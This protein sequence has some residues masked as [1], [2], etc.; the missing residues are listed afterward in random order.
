MDE[1]AP[2]RWSALDPRLAEA[3]ARRGIREPTEIQQLAAP[4]L[5]GE[6]DALLLSPR[7]PVRRKR[8]CCPCSPDGSPTRRPR[9]RS[10]TSPPFGP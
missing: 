10:C 6:D 3:A 5:E 9:S 7:A 8:P 4:I 2:E 1:P